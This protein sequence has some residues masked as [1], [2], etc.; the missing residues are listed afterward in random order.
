MAPKVAA[1][2]SPS[3]AS[4]PDIRSFRPGVAGGA[5]GRGEGWAGIE[6]EPIP[7][8]SKD[9]RYS[10]YLNRVRRMIKSKWIYPCVKD[11]ATSE[12]EYKAAKLVIVFGILKDGRV[13]RVD[14]AE[15]SNYEI[16]DD[17]AVTAIK[18]AQPFPPIPAELMAAT[19]P[20]SAGIRIMA[21][22]HYIL[23]SSLANILR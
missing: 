5:G 2:P 15:P 16:Y 13:P 8:D 7:L 12:C 14:V 3:R 18:L 4:T 6:G 9:T 23:E 17:V 1:A 21:S 11:P 20:G 10:D 22:F 19:P